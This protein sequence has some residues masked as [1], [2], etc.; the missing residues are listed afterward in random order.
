MSLKTN[1]VGEVLL[2]EGLLARR[3]FADKTASEAID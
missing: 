3:V 2:F 1:V